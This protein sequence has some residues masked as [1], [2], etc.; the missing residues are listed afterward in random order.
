MSN[1][2]LATADERIGVLSNWLLHHGL[3]GTPN[4]QILEG[5][6]EQLCA[7]GVPLLRFHVT[8]NALHPVYGAVGFDWKQDT[9]VVEHAYAHSQETPAVWYDSPFYYM[10]SQDVT[11]YREKMGKGRPESRFPLL[12][13]MSTEGAT[14]YLAMMMLYIERD[15]NVPLS[16]E[17][18]GGEE[19][20]LASWMAHAPGGFEDRDVTLI[21]ET[22]P[23][24]SLVIK[25]GTNRKTAEDLLG[26]YLGRDAGRR[27][28][29]GEI[30]RGSSQ[31]ID[32]V[33]CYFDLAGFT[34]MS[35]KIEGEAL[36]G[37]L[38]DYFGLVVSQ[39]EAHKGDVLK[40]MGDGLIAIFD[41]STLEDAAAQALQA[42]IEIGA[43]MEAR[44]ADR[45]GQGVP[46]LGYTVALHAGQV[47]YGNIGADERLDFT[48][49]GPEMNLA[50]RL[51]DMHRPL[52]RNVIV[53]EAAL[54]A[55]PPEAYELVSLGRYM[56]RG[57]EHPLELF[58]L[59]DLSPH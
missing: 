54:A 47:L 51:G 35:Q 19:G 13:Q 28:L 43:G 38:N 6:C 17:L 24:L 52:G 53:S 36:I 11:E 2:P 58:T 31:W 56:L 30:Q 10:L 41:R 27:V 5:Y 14:E 50:A 42:V 34:N 32:A 40:F 55:A 8:H 15:E 25:S 33:I 9:D 44:N 20:A 46:T 16:P 4:L 18:E 21:R 7:L 12:R 59:H 39:I 45:A 37:M 23:L 22:F 49:I 57:V 3:V 1:T 48:V 29:M 26:I